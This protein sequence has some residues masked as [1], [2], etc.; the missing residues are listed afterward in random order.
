MRV[1]PFRPVDIS[2]GAPMGRRDG[3]IA[4]DPSFKRLCACNGYGIGGYDTGGANW[5]LPQNIWCVWNAGEYE[6]RK[7]LRA[8]SREQAIKTATRNAIKSSYG[9]RCVDYDPD[10]PTCQTWS[11]WDVKVKTCNWTHDNRWTTRHRRR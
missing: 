8:D 1:K 2:H 3:H 9:E 5:G 4:L 10:C 7:Y 6:T 11:E